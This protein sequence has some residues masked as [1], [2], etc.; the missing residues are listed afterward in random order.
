MN[1]HIPAK[2][3]VSIW[4][5]RQVTSLGI[6]RSSKLL[7]GYDTPMRDAPLAPLNPPMLALNRIALSRFLLW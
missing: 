5:G 2:H 7:T 1:G 3:F 6:T 4:T